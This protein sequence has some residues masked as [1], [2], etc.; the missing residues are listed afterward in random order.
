[1][2]T[3]RDVALEFMRKVGDTTGSERSNVLTEI[4]KSK[5]RAGDDSELLSRVVSNIKS[6]VGTWLNN[7]NSSL[8][9]VNIEWYW[10]A[11]EAAHARRDELIPDL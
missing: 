7:R 10:G 9:N 3:V 11:E 6:A 5:L 1:M 2:T 8:G 4:V